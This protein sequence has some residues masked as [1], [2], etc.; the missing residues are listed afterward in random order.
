VSTPLWTTGTPGSGE[1][2]GITQEVA[3]TSEKVAEVIHDAIESQQYHGGTILEVS[4]FGVRVIPEWHIDPPGL[5]DGKIAKGTDVPP[6]MM[7]KALMP[8]LEVTERER[9]S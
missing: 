8:V 3:I 6:E 7:A 2:F 4:G 9:G 5:V 1:R